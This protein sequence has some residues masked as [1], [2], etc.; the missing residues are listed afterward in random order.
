MTRESSWKAATRLFRICIAS[1]GP[2]ARELKDV[3]RR[4]DRAEQIL[5]IQRPLNMPELG[6]LGPAYIHRRFS[7]VQLTEIKLW[8]SEVIF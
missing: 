1:A 4:S 7:A 2:A 3:F 6:P 5:A 8:S